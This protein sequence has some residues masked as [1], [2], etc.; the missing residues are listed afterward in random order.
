MR[1]DLRLYWDIYKLLLHHG[2]NYRFHN[3]AF[4]YKSCNMGW[5]PSCDSE[6]VIDLIGGSKNVIG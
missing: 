4:E 2:Q 6:V 1:S 3:G 5:Y